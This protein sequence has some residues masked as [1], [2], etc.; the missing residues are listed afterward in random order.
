MRLRSGGPVID[1]TTS[2]QVSQL[3]GHSPAWQASGVERGDQIDALDA[4]LLREFAAAPRVG[5]LE[6][7]RRLGVARATVQS[8]LDRLVERGVID[9]FAPRLSTE[10]LGYAVTAF[11]TLEISQGRGA[12]V[13][14]HLRRIPE[15]LEVHTITGPGDLL[16]RLVAR[17]NTDLQRVIDTVVSQPAIERTSTSIAMSN[18][19]GFR[20]LPL[21][22]R[23]EDVAG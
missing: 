11:A 13:L 1:A 16:C 3:V 20:V 9:D 12:E 15:V 17:S 23:V 8:R 21:V 7:S 22:R 2:A 4:R 6:L 14:D 10:A 19:V 18:P 5:V